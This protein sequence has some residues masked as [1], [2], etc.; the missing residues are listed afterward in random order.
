MVKIKVIGFVITWLCFSSFVHMVYVLHTGF[1][2]EKKAIHAQEIRVLYLISGNDAHVQVF[3]RQPK[4]PLEALCA[5]REDCKVLA[6]AV[7][8]EARGEP[9]VG[10]QAVA[11]VIM[12]RVEDEKFPDTVKDV[13]YQKHQFSFVKDMHKQKPPTKKDIDTARRIAYN[14]I[15]KKIKS[16]VGKALYFHSVNVNPVWSKGIKKKTIGNHKF[17]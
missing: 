3:R 6:K 1:Y 8:F 9:V 10:Q 17:F 11:A 16:P 13:V 2:P 5:A 14:V 15:T 7:V 12:N 4:K